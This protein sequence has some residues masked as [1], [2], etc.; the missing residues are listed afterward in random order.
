MII[1]A[2][3]NSMEVGVLGTAQTGDPVIWQQWNQI[4]AG[5][6]ELPLAGHQQE[7]FPLGIAFDT[8]ITHQLPWGKIIITITILYSA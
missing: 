3:A 7:T 6:A 4:D 2:S 5:R 8:G 1:V